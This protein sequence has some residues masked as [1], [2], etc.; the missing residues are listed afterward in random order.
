MK[1]LL[2]YSEK[3]ESPH[4]LT[5]T[6]IQSRAVRLSWSTGFDGNSPLAGFTLQH[7][8]LAAHAQGALR[9]DQWDAATAI[10]V[11]LHT[12]RTTHAAVT[13]VNKYWHIV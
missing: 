13:Y 7:G 8:A 10:N 6:E 3:P 11:T 1:H 4:S 12:P 2:L 9:P 5:V